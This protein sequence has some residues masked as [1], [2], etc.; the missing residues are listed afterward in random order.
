VR[1]KPRF[2][3]EKIHVRRSELVRLTNEVAAEC[4]KMF[5]FSDISET[6]AVQKDRFVKR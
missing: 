3:K 2:L 4:L 5:G 1:P 6:D